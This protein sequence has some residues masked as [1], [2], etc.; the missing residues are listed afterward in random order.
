MH[1]NSR[2]ILPGLFLLLLGVSVQA[3]DNGFYISVGG[4]TKLVDGTNSSV[5][6]T[7][8]PFEQLVVNETCVP[9][10]CVAVV[11]SSARG[12]G[13]SSRFYGGFSF[14]VGYRFL[15]RFRVSVTVDRFFDKKGGQT[16]LWAADPTGAYA[17]ETGIATYVSDFY[18]TDI[19]IEAAYYP[20][21]I[22]GLFFSAGTQIGM[23]DADETLTWRRYQSGNDAFTT[24]ITSG[25]ETANTT[26][27][28]MGVGY[29]HQLARHLVLTSSFTYRFYGYT[30]GGKL[31]LGLAY[32]V[33]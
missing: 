23:I 1:L 2:L 7:D 33:F 4:A 21:R 24:L 12:F 3:L 15:D 30:A 16:L 8:P 29:D 9:F 20:E 18:Y 13:V 14:G 27:I 10:P 11:P 26:N 28:E 5:D 19:S 32:T 17:G 22:L 25:G 31:R 6:L